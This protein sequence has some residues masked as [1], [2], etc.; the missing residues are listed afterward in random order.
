MKKIQNDCLASI[1][2][3]SDG[4]NRR[5]MLL[6]MGAAAAALMEIYPGAFALF[7]MAVTQGCFDN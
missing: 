1:E 3:G 6:G 5:C 7:G 4:Q 2:A